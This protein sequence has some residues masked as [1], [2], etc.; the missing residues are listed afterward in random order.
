MRIDWWTLALQAVNFL[1]LVWL[2]QRFLYRPVLRVLARRKAEAEKVLSQAA[3]ARKEAD[4]SRRA[5]EAKEA[6]VAAERE[7]MLKEARTEVEAARNEALARARKEAEELLAAAKETIAAART[8]AL[9]EVKGAAADLGVAIARNLL[10]RT[11][12]PGLMAGFLDGICAHLDGL[13]RHDLAALRD[14][15]KN[16]GALEV[17]TAEPLDAQTQ[18]HWKECLAKRLDGAGAIT[19]RADEARIAGAELHFPAAVLRFNWKDALESARKDLIA[20][21]DAE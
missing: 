10:K 19:F 18:A 1:I 9:Q 15:I 5:Y 17:A 7:A 14:Q 8:A 21:D 2:L 13:P 12:G 16:G 11:A 3:D 20:D 4:E 6:G